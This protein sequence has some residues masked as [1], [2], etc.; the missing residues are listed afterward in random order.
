MYNPS[1]AL[2]H[3]DNVLRHHRTL[4]NLLAAVPTPLSVFQRMRQRLDDNERTALEKLPK[5]YPGRWRDFQRTQAGNHNAADTARTLASYFFAQAELLHADGLLSHEHRLMA[6]SVYQWPGVQE[7]AQYFGAVTRA[8]GLQLNGDEH[9]AEC[10]GS[11]VLVE[12]AHRPLQTLDQQAEVGKLL[13]FT[14]SCGVEPFDTLTH[15]RARLSRPNGRQA[16]LPGLRERDRKRLSNTPH[17]PIS[18]QEVTAPL[19]TYL[20]E[21]WALKQLDDYGYH[22]RH[23]ELSPLQG[24]EWV[25]GMSRAVDLRPAFDPQGFF[26]RRTAALLQAAT[27][28]W[29]AKA[30]TAARQALASR[31][32][33]VL[34]HSLQ[35][36]QLMH[37]LPSLKQYA[38]AQVEGQLRRRL[39]R[40]IDI[41][42]L[43]VSEARVLGLIPQLWKGLPWLIYSEIKRGR[44]VTPL[45]DKALSNISPAD[46]D[47]W[48]T[49]I[50]VDGQG[51]E[52]PGLNAN[53]IR[54][55]VRDIDVGAHYP[56]FIRSQIDNAPHL[57]FH[58]A[59][60]HLQ[61]ARH[62]LLRQ[63][64]A[65]GAPM[66]ASWTPTLKDGKLAQAT[67]DALFE[68]QIE[69]LMAEAH[70]ASTS[71]RDS[72]LHLAVNLCTTVASTV[73]S[74]A[75]PWLGLAVNG[76]LSVQAVVNGVSALKA[77]NYQQAVDDIG[78][79][80]TAL[81]PLPGPSTHE[82]M[83]VTLFRKGPQ[84]LQPH[85]LPGRAAMASMP[86]T[87]EATVSLAHVP[88]D[89]DGVHHHHGRHYIRHIESPTQVRHL[90]VEFST[91][92]GTYRTLN[93]ERPDGFKQ[94]VQRTDDLAWRPHIAALP[95]PD[96]ER[97][98]IDEAVQTMDSARPPAPAVEHASQWLDPDILAQAG[99]D[100]LDGESFLE[101]AQL[102]DQ[103]AYRFTDDT[104]LPPVQPSADS[105]ILLARPAMEIW[106]RSLA[107]RHISLPRG[108]L[109][110]QEEV[111]YLPAE[112]VQANAGV[113]TQMSNDHYSNV[114]NISAQRDR[115]IRLT[116]TVMEQLGYVYL[117]SP[118]IHGIPLLVC[119]H[120]HSN[121]C[122]VV[123][124][125]VM[126]QNVP[127]RVYL[128]AR[129]VGV[130][131]GSWPHFIFD[132]L[133]QVML[134]PPPQLQEA[135][136]QRRLFPVMAV[137]DLGR[138]L[139][140]TRI[141]LVRAAFM[142]PEH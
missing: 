11:F 123:Y 2:Q 42:Q 28:A 87:T 129:M 9:T 55:I 78:G 17:A 109:E 96:I 125:R 90:Q 94:P 52:V 74:A 91:R 118:G 38:K 85:G 80:L 40:R 122:Y 24:V 92:H 4:Q 7:R 113:L 34:R 128:P 83:P 97:A 126:F 100:T 33:V 73:A 32:R 58:R 22:L 72:D 130:G 45:V 43:Y 111:L 134:A 127:G 84:Q 115:L 135:L 10:L 124:P 36:N 138:T 6:K 117:A 120:P 75:D 29:L 104:V 107:S 116:R 142:Q 64:A 48:L 16:M 56:A 49:A 57:A 39:K 110:Q 8:Y 51:H 12:H 62:A 18:F 50:V 19:F 86:P 61:Y 99:L 15:L 1:N 108:L 60:A 26:A 37:S 53:L 131:S 30:P 114:Q 66:P 105:D 141:C 137:V 47:Y 59:F 20:M 101:A 35:F 89:I 81:V 119:T 54:D 3:Y 25:V 46:V 77:G 63:R 69:A 41:D 23:R 112:H 70:A 13:L 140:S 98:V 102:L 136:A 133:S 44:D 68:T 93:A 103:Q 76:L 31:T 121:G 27:P 5:A 21:G 71:N 132:E 139:D 82:H 67:T 79:A 65:M 14:P 95:N 106:P 88:P